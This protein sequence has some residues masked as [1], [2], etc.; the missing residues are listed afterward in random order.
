MT[1]SLGEMKTKEPQVSVTSSTSATLE[2]QKPI[3]LVG[4]R[5]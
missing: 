4:M 3:K 2:T 1:L 5:K